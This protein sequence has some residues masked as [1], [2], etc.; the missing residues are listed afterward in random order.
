MYV[1]M[2]FLMRTVRIFTSRV[3]YDDSMLAPTYEDTCM[4]LQRQ[5][6]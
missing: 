6:R 3:C 4:H 2:H 1:Y 5:P